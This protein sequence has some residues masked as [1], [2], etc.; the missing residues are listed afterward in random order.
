MVVSPTAPGRLEL[1]IN[2]L[3]PTDA[4][5]Y[6]CSSVNDIGED[7]STANITVLCKLRPYPEKVLVKQTR[8]GN[9][10]P[11]QQGGVYP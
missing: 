7:N 11:I 4:G 6:I 8:S 10:L 2:N 3:L 9:H 1:K 5:Q